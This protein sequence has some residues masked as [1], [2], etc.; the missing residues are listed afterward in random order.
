MGK[1]E[2]SGGMFQNEKKHIP[3]SDSPKNRDWYTRSW[4]LCPSGLWLLDII[5]CL[6]LFT[7]VQM[8]QPLSKY[9]LSD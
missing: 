4:T 8:Q 2:G 6:S 7:C 3:D 1:E 5:I 9:L